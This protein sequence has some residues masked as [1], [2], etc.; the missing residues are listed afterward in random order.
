MQPAADGVATVLPAEFAAGVQLRHDD[1]NGGGAGGVHGHRD[2]AP[3]VGY[4]DA[5]VVEDA[6][7]DAGG[8]AGHRLVD[9]VVDHLPNEVVQAPLTGRPDIHAGAF[10]DSLQPFEHG[11]R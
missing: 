2:A 11:D 8:V 9:R 4:L 7:I 1:I 5:A 3:V 6:D 10:A